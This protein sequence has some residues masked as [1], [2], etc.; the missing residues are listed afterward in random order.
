[1]REHLPVRLV[2]NTTSRAHRT[3]FESLRG[4]GLID[5]PDDLVTPATAARRVLTSRDHAGGILLVEPGAREDFSWFEESADGPAVLLGTEGQSLRI[6]DLQPAF[7]AILA[8]SAFYTLQKNRYF[9]KGSDLVT[10][11]GPLAA[12]LAYAT[13]REAQN[14]GKPSRL[15]FEALASEAGAGLDQLVMVGDDAEFDAS[16]S[17]AHGMAGVLV[18]TGKYRPGDEG[19][20]EP[21]PTA[22]IDSV[23]DLPHWLGL[24]D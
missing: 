18:R 20:V 6:E 23:A 17:V 1:L 3:L 19:R 22:V 7:R 8:D 13:G 10:D 16:G 4:F 15:L 5:R 12:F 2:T 24:R 21:P 11:L 14:L 9:R